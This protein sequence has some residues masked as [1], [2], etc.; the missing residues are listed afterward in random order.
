MR[1]LGI[2]PGLAKL[3]WGIIDTSEGKETVL[4]EYGCVST[5]SSVPVSDRLGHIYEQICELIKKFEPQEVAIERLF[6][7]SNTKT[8]MDVAQA[9]GSVLVALNHSGIRIYEYTPL[10]IKQALVGYGRATKDQVQFMVKNFLNMK[11][12]PE[13]D[14]A[15]DGLAAAICHNSHRKMNEIKEKR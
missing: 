5:R 7:S 2:D 12:V 8:A 11:E 9:K 3:G 15:A 4:V 6:F 10:Q 14:H 13:P 1:I